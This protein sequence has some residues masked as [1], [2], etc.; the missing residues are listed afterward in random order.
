MRLDQNFPNPMPRS[1]QH[2][3]RIKWDFDQFWPKNAGLKVLCHWVGCCQMSVNLETLFW[4]MKERWWGESLV[5]RIIRGLDVKLI[6]QS[7]ARIMKSWPI[8][9]QCHNKQEWQSLDI[10]LV[11]W[12]LG[13]VSHDH[14]WVTRPEQQQSNVHTDGCQ[15]IKE[16]SDIKIL[17][18][19]ILCFRCFSPER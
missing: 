7:E 15:E 10:D 16:E 14:N 17:S 4:R 19:T 2:Q 18:Y 8:R 13:R 12:G 11:T 3:A 5:N 1:G 9:G 6:D